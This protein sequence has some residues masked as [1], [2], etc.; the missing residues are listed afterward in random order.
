MKYQQLCGLYQQLDSTAKR[1]EK[2]WLISRFLQKADAKELPAIILLLQGLIYPEYDE[3]K[4][5]IASRLLVKAINVATGIEAAKIEEEWKKTGDLGL[6]AERFIAKKKQATLLSRDIDVEKVLANLRR[7]SGLEGEGTVERKVKLI[8]E[9]LTSAQPVEAR[10]IVRTTLEDLRVGVAAGTLRDAI[11]WAF[12]EKE[13]KIHYDEKT[14]SIEPE[15]RERYKEIV[16]AVQAAHDVC[17]DYSEVAL[18]AKTK[19]LRGLQ[20]MGLT[21]GK[22]VKVMLFQKAKDIAD[23][24]ERVGKPC[25]FEYKYDG[26]RIEVHKEGSTIILYTRRLEEVTRQ[27]PEIVEYVKQQVKGD[28][29]IL[30]AEAVG[31]HPKTKKYL[32]F[33]SISQRIRRKYDIDKI[34]KEFPVELNVFDV[35]YYNG[36]NMMETPFAKR[37]ELI[38]K[39]VEP[40]PYKIR[41]ATQLVTDDMKKAEAFYKAAVDAG[42]EGV[43]AK[44]LDGIYKP[45]LR[46]GFGV[47]VKPTMETLDLTIVGAE[48]GEGKRK[49]WL[50]TFTLACRDEENGE[51]LEIGKVGTGFKELETEGGVTF[52][53][54][55]RLLEPLIISGKGKEVK[56]KPKVV[57]EVTYEEIQKSPTYA[58]GY[59][60]RFPRLVNLRVEKP[61][62]EASSL[63]MIEE[64]YYGQKGK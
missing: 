25:A 57:I 40:V 27:F 48:W 19:G 26:F 20:E 52:D 9:L 23:A 15:N 13:I 28:S 51:F 60:L 55:T 24:F 30:D 37:R 11:T 47:K 12:F 58:S 21:V 38:E 44:N 36:K 5:G 2:T 17:N 35:I 43:M 29:F 6:T 45:G 33:Q 50:S 8:A 56:I 10:Y 7:A 54:M 64:M 1:L 3:R 42:E 62:D 53:Q 63:Q 4:I 22:P 41:V 39:I 32:P 14:R 16:A 34:A 49:G 61:A 18:L 46:V 59:A 31:F